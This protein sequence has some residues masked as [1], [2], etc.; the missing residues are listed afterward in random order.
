MLAAEFEEAILT[1][2]R[3]G[4]DLSQ[5]LCMPESQNCRTLIHS[6]LNNKR[7]LSEIEMMNSRIAQLSKKWI[8]C[9]EK[10][11]RQTREE[12]SKLVEATKMEAMKLNQLCNLAIEKITKAKVEMKEGIK[13]AGKGAQFLQSVKPIKNNYPKFIDSHC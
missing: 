12:I 7:C 11:D 4:K 3:L 2:K 9:R 10:L 8:I 13:E 6:I 5:I 1:Y